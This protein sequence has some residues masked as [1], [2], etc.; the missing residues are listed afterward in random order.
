[1]SG[2]HNFDTDPMSHHPTLSTKPSTSITEADMLDSEDSSSVHSF[3]SEHAVRGP[4]P[5][6]VSTSLIVASNI[7]LADV[8]TEEVTPHM[9]VQREKALLDRA[10]FSVCP[11]GVVDSKEHYKTKAAKAPLYT[12]VDFDQVDALCRQDHDLYTGHLHEQAHGVLP[13]AESLARLFTRL[14]SR[15]AHD[16]E[17]AAPP[18]EPC[19]VA[20]DV[21]PYGRAAKA[22]E[23]KKRLEKEKRKATLHEAR[24]LMFDCQVPVSKVARRLCV[25]YHRM[26]KV[27]KQ[28]IIDPE[29]ALGRKCHRS[30]FTKIHESA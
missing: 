3:W 15:V 26:L 10:G 2:Q 25:P 11:F 14:H 6:Y 9:V 16:H 24:Y 1:M 28:K 5:H 27:F 13:P 17:G 21:V 12:M 18:S 20:G 22:N 7:T 8:H 19:G 30:R 23:K 29:L 4:S